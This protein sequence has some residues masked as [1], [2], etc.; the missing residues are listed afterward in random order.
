MKCNLTTCRHNKNGECQSAE[1]RKVCVDVAKKVLVEELESKDHI[2]KVLR[3]KFE[4][5]RTRCFIGAEKY[6]DKDMYGCLTIVTNRNVA[7]CEDDGK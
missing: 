4:Y 6:F 5:L 3:G 7:R 2:I 1:D